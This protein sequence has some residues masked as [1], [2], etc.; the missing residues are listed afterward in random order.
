MP[1]FYVVLKVSV[2]LCLALISWLLGC[3]YLQ[4]WW[5]TR[6]WHSVL[7]SLSTHWSV[8]MKHYRL[9]WPRLMSWTS[10]M[11]AWQVE[12]VF[13][14]S[15]YVNCS[16]CLMVKMMDCCMFSLFWFLDLYKSPVVLGTVFNCNCWN[17]FCNNYSL[18]VVVSTDCSS[19]DCSSS[20]CCSRS[21]SHSSS[22][23]MGS[24]P[25]QP[26]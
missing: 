25:G 21:H 6:W 8:L 12:F 20:S 18:Q 17:V 19:T 7:V 13:T 22:H 1:Y 4:V 3:C 24:F 5:M 2:W 26:W 11:Y 15:G 9:W 10:K 14:I 23:L 16:H